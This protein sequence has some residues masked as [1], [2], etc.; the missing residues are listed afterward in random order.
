[1][2]M[3]VNKHGIAVPSGDHHHTKWIEDCGRL[4]HD[5]SLLPIIRP[6]LKRVCVDIGA[7]IG[8]HSLWYAKHCERVISFEPCPVAFACLEHNMRDLGNV[9]IHNVALGAT[10]GTV[11][12]AMHD[13]NLGATQTIDGGDIPRRTLDSFKLGEVDYIK[14]DA[15]GDEIDILEGGRETI[16]RMRPVMLIELN[17]YAMA[18]RGR[19]GGDL[20]DA[21]HSLGYSTQMIDSNHN[22]EHCD[23]ICFPAHAQR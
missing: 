7:H 10:E 1:M 3:L 13:G 4:D 14:I 2:H 21:I 12:F 16:G 11:S 19:T 9:T 6:Y 23:L 22:P 5:Q 15:E 18:N 8:S 20:K 17:E